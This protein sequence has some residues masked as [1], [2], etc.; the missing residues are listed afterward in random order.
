MNDAPYWRTHFT[1]AFYYQQQYNT[2][3]CLD[4]IRKANLLKPNNYGIL[5]RKIQ[6]E[7]GYGDDQHALKDYDDFFKITPEFSDLP[8]YLRFVQERKMW[9]RVIEAGELAAK[10]G[11][12]EDFSS[13]LEHSKNHLKLDEDIEKNPSAATYVARGISSKFQLVTE[14]GEA[15]LAENKTSSAKEDFEKALEISPSDSKVRVK[16]FSM[17]SR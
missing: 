12:S 5:K 11:L 8:N 15:W 6:L 3:Q 1:L 13:E 7:R 14:A 17:K 4:H 10:A 2:A 16:V 9:K